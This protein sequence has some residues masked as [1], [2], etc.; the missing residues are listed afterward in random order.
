MNYIFDKEKLTQVLSDFY[1]S[2][3]IAVALYDAS[4]R[5]VAGSP[6]HSPFCTHIH[7]RK[8]CIDHCNQSNLIHMK[9][10]SLNWQISRY[11]CHAGVMEVIF[12]V[13]YEDVLI[14]YIQI[15]QFRDAE[16][17]YSRA[18]KLPEIAEQY[19]FSLERL[20][21]L[22]DEL[23]LV[24]DERLN[25]L[26]HIVDILVKSFWQDGL[27]TYNR[28]MLSIKIENYIDEHLG[29]KIGLNDICNEFL[30]SKNLVY[31]LF[32]NEFN[33]TVNNLITEKRLYRAKELLQTSPE[34]NITQVSLLCGFSDYNYFIRVFKKQFG[35][36]PLQLR[37][38]GKHKE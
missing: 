26:C 12:P 11:A 10:V 35:I 37:K 14:A 22:Y 23:S 33:T 25:S 28:S 31:Q 20:Q 15:G 21:V 5:S 1:N 9:E 13:I 30:L 8:E 32:R 7:N 17:R 27:I 34:L 2:T 38:A 18:D 24:S 36:T 19:G 6:I 4:Q 3:G 29:E 16:H